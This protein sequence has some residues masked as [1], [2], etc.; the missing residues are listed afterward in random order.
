MTRSEALMAIAYVARVEAD[1]ADWR[2]TVA[3]MQG[4][5]R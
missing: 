1:D 5:P 4:G 3:W 2:R